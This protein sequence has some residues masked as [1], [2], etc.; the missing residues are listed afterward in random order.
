MLNFFQKRKKDTKKELHD[1]LGDY[2]LPSFSAAVMTVLNALRDPDFSMSAITEQLER[3]P[4]LHV[5]VL[6][7]VNSAAF[8][9]SKRVGNLHHAVTLLGR[10]RLETIVL[11]QAVNSVLPDVKLSFF[12]MKQFWLCAA[13]RASLARALAQ[14]IHPT[15]QVECFTAGLLQDMALPILVSVKQK[16]YGTILENWNKTK[17]A[18]LNE[19]EKEMLGFDHSTV[20][21]LMAKE[22]NLPEYLI[23]AISGHH[24][25]S[26]DKEVKIEPAVELVAQIKGDS[27]E[28]AK[29]IIIKIAVEKNGMD[30]DLISEL[31]T[32]AFKDAEEL[33][34]LLR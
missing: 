28:N 24:G 7:T 1:L 18:S 3:D 9:L 14:H 23:D 32:T 2:E 4:G 12:D 5:K 34:L 17:D 31:I 13:R 15:S 25:Q 29:E 27:E 21:A 16:E 26:Q 6:K 11:S 19:L 33:S 22:W 20:G 30:K 8:G 10:S